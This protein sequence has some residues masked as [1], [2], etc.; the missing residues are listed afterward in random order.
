MRVTADMPGR[1]A[2]APTARRRYRFR[3]G[4]IA[5][6]GRAKVAVLIGAAR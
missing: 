1:M 2:G 5:A 3:R 6:G 4:L